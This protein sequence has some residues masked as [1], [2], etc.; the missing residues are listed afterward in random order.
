MLQ[1]KKIK[2]IILGVLAISAFLVW[3]AYFSL[4]PTDKLE[5][6]FF[7]VGQG[8]AA[9]IETPGHRQILIDGGPDNS[10]L[11]KIGKELPF[12]DRTIDILIVTHP[13][14]DHL[15]GAVEVIKNYD[16]GM[17]LVNGKECA[18]K[19]CAEFDKVVKEKNSRVVVA[20]AGQEI[21]FGND[22]K[23]NIFLPNIALAASGKD[24]DNNFS[25][26][27][28]LAYGADSFLFMGDAEAKE[29]LWLLSAW[30]DLTAEVLKVGHHGS[31]N[32][33]NQLFLEK[34]N[35][36]FSVIFV[37]AKNTYGHPHIETIE[38]LKKI[39]SEILRT[40]LG[41]DVM[42]ETEGD[43]VTIKSSTEH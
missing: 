3:S 42:M 38:A 34:I 22:I 1:Q 2:F 7:D 43:G 19:I 27:S 28:R 5:V 12:Y 39:G 40:D 24:E 30:P 29:E 9:M 8:D 13:D 25:I 33:T 31:K 16:I 4:R 32:S 18:T 41:G 17:I 6:R 26:I 10:I 20:R 15:A 37:G 11:A 21:D 23:M 14:S 36:K 35:P